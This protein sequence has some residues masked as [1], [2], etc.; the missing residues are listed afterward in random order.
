M[1]F[2]SILIALLTC[3]VPLSALYAAKIDAEQSRIY[4]GFFGPMT[5]ELAT[6]EVVG[7]RIRYLEEP[8]RIVFDFEEMEFGQLPDDFGKKLKKLTKFQ[9]GQLREGARLVLAFNEPIKV[10]NVEFSDQAIDGRTGLRVEFEPI[11][12]E[13]F[14]D[15]ALKLPQ[16]KMEGIALEAVEP[17]SAHLPLI[18]IDAGHGGIDPGAQRQKIKEKDITLKASLIVEQYLESTGRYR[19]VLTRE[20]DVFNS[21][22]ARRQFAERL[23]ANL[24]LS[25]H[26]DALAEG[27]A[28]GTTIYQVSEEASSQI[29]EH[30]SAFENRVELFAGEI[31]YDDSSDMGVVLTNM[32]YQTS[33]ER[34]DELARILQREWQS[35]NVV[36]EESKRESADFALLKTPEVP[37]LLLEIGYMSNDEDLVKIQNE[38]WLR[39]MAEGLESALAEFFYDH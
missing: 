10:K 36:P 7:V 16:K 35:I 3:F 11:A 34:A 33:R 13:E 32:A 29:A 18:V 23:G 37:S 21:L 1:N 28:R 14:H 9:Y 8:Y 24:F 12:N 6:D 27:N 20:E 5:M 15:L 22:L 17:E 2:S 30:F 4:Q 26:A 25:F 38:A 31:A 39:K 19:V